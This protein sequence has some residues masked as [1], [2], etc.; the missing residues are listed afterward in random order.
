MPRASNTIIHR[1][2]GRYEARAMFGDV[3]QRQRRSFFGATADDA[4][5]KLTRAQSQQDSGQAPPP[6]RATV[7]AYLRA[8]LKV[9]EPALRPESFRRYREAVELHLVPTIGKMRLARLTATQVE[10]AYAAIRAKGLSGTSVQL[11]H[12]VLRK[13][14][15]DAERRGEVA[16]N[17]ATLVDAPRRSTR[18]MRPLTAAEAVRLLDAARGDELE[19]FYSVALTTGLRLGEL[20]ALR[21]REVDLD[22]RRLRV[23]A[24]LAGVSQGVPVLAPP[25]T[26]RSRREVHL[27][28]VASDALRQHRS[29]QLEQR[30][31]IGPIWEDHDLVFANGRGRPLDANNIRTRSFTR[32]LARAGLPPM[33]FHALRHAAASLLLAQGVNVKVIAEVLGHADVTVTL[34]VYAHLMPSAQQ[35]AA[36]AM[37]QLFAGR[38]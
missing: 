1:P 12:G 10:G 34:R 28:D 5:R 38:G 18:E 26:Q 33:R 22:R 35:E 30:L 25:K 13:A 9:K 4:R 19:A 23:T 6:E 7:A 14:L 32:L 37:D 24:T 29:R 16:R 20:Q 15:H 11:V 21:W 8:W 27:S 36:A 2:D 31:A 17:V 3:G